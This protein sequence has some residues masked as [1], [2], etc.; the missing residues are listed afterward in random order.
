MAN[1]IALFCGSSSGNDPRYTENIERLAE[2][3]V[4]RKYRV[5]YGGASVGAMG[6]VADAVLRRGGEV[7]GVIPQQLF[8]YEIAHTDLS[9]LHVVA[10]MHERKAR[11]ASLS[12]A[13]IA[14]PGGFGTLDEF[15]EILTWAQLGLHACPTGLLNT[16]GYF[17]ALLQFFDHAVEEHFLRDE[18]RNAVLHGESPAELLDAMESW[19]PA[20]VNKWMHPDGSELQLGDV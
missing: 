9:E 2:E 10:S 5:V 12:D 17:D 15:A 18:N 6:A 4:Q 11:I 20:N 3:L 8:A 1:S 16:L 7:I 19:Q 13:F 14:L